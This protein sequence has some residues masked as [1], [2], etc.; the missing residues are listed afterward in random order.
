VTIVVS[1]SSGAHVD[2]YELFLERCPDAL[3]YHT[4]AYH[5]MLSRICGTGE[6]ILL[7]AWR[8]GRIAGAMTVFVKSGECGRVAN[9]SPYFGSH[10]DILIAGD[11]E[12]PD[13]VADLL[14]KEFS[15]FC[16]RDRVLAANVVCHPLRSR[17][18][19]LAEVH[20]FKK[21]DSRI[22]QI[23]HLPE[24]HSADPLELVL[25][26]CHQKTRNLVRK[27]LRAG[28]AIEISDRNSDWDDLYNHHSFGMEKIGGRAKKPYEFQSLR[29]AL[30]SQCKL[31][32][33]RKDGVFA[34]AL[35]NL[36][37]R[38]WIEYFTPVA[39][40]AFRSE[41]VLSA[42]IAS[43]MCD[44]LRTGARVW[45]WGGTWSTQAGVYHFKKGWGAKDYP[46]DYCG[47]LWD[48]NLALLSPDMLDAQFRYF[49]VL[50][51]VR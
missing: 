25:A 16:T 3:L 22:G 46:Y 7:A 20:G 34:G 27:G 5:G 10:G 9:A 33:A 6:P 17:F 18:A 14:G 42:L 47:A 45:N 8:N 50:P 44:G 38:D 32:V 21:W 1:V 29:A 2:D 12:N 4:P 11:E 26:G 36:Y 51:Y 15:N 40:E 41:Q 49:Y 39:V 13:A 31:Y 43:A 30:K 28:F 23:S 24:I 19:A 37:Y 48:E 35:L